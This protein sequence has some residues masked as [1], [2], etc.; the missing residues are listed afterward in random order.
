MSVII[1]LLTVV[2]GIWLI[3]REPPQDIEDPTHDYL[4]VEAYDWR[5]RNN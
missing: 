5:G 2:I 4:D 1:P 3:R